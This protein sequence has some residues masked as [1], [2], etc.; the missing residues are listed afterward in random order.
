M[1]DSNFA[2]Q[3]ATVDIAT[4][5]CA[6][7]LVIDVVIVFVSVATSPVPGYEAAWFDAILR[8][9]AGVGVAGALALA[10]IVSLRLRRRRLKAEMEA[11]DAER[12][13]QPKA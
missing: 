5:I 6:T 3:I 7:V 4:G 10:G 12:R 1:T 8:R 2:K 13:F 9:F 11:A